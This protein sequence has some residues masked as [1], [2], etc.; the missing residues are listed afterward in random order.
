MQPAA[1]SA[2]ESVERRAFL[3]GGLKLGLLSRG[4]LSASV[5]AASVSACAQ[6]PPAIAA[7]FKFLRAE[8]IE[9][10]QA[11]S[12][13]VLKPSLEGFTSSQP[14]VIQR[15]DALAFNLDAP[16]RRQV[17]QLFDLLAMRASRWLTTGIAAP[18]AEAS[19]A[20]MQAFL[21]RWRDSSLGLFN[22]GYRVLTKFLAAAFFSLPESRVVSAYPGPQDWALKALAAEAE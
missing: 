9:L 1:T 5:V 18:W 22:V 15:I 20:E 7:G 21:E 17:Y 6:Q 3:A 12:R 10:F 14:L 19:D 4:I 2:A 16:A 11:L 8:D 13:V